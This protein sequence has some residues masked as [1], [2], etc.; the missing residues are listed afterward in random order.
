MSCI[1][2]EEERGQLKTV[3]FMPRHSDRRPARAHECAEQFA[4]RSLST[5]L[6]TD[7]S[8]VSSLNRRAWFALPALRR[9]PADR[10]RRCAALGGRRKT[11]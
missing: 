6:S 9:G 8:R 7:C 1:A 10:T 2:R 4:K 5:W 3:L 11:S